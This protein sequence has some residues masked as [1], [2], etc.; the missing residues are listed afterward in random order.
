MKIVIAAA[1]ALFSTAAV[2]NP[3]A[4]PERFRGEPSVRYIVIPVP[5][6]EMPKRCGQKPNP[7]APLMGCAYTMR[8]PRLCVI[9]I[10]TRSF[11]NLTLSMFLYP[12]ITPRMV[13]EHE[14]GHCKGWPANHP[15]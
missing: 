14:K 3:F 12:V 8:K 13:L 1:L 6:S 2:A 9:H 5:L 4:P 10:P 7:L 15:K 11:P